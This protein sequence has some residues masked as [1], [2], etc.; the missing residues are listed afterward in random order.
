MNVAKF[1][2]IFAAFGY[3]VRTQTACNPGYF[4]DPSSGNCNQ[5]SSGCTYCLSAT[6]CGGCRLKYF[7]SESSCLSCPVGCNSCASL[8]KCTTCEKAFFMRSESCVAC[9]TGCTEC[10]ETACSK[11]LPG[12]FLNAG[13]CITCTD[14]CEECTNLVCTKC[15]SDYNLNDE[16][17]C[18]SESSL[19]SGVLAAI[20]ISAIIV[21]AVIAICTVFTIRKFINKKAVAPEATVVSERRNLAANQNTSRGLIPSQ[22]RNDESNGR[23]RSHYTSRLPDPRIFLPPGFTQLGHET[24][25]TDPGPLPGSHPLLARISAR[26]PSATQAARAPPPMQIMELSQISNAGIPTPYVPPFKASQPPQY[27]GIR[28]VRV[29]HI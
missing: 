1:L 26:K 2:A 11:C 13:T 29:T 23:Y 20:I 14:N 27:P 4:R 6:E 10:S 8:T 19:S 16:G 21:V 18:Y 9:S 17:S 15:A 5:C 22:N 24:P 12:W 7:L 25:Y 3:Q 28:P